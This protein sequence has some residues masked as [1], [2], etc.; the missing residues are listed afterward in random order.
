[1]SG[2][3]QKIEKLLQA[4]FEHGFC[5]LA[6]L[7]KPETIKDLPK[8]ARKIAADME[9]KKKIVIVGDYDVDGV[10]S[11]ALL[12]DFFDTAGYGV[13]VVIPNRFVDGYGLSPTLIER[14]EADLIITVDNG[15]SAVEAADLCAQKGIDL[16]IT[17]HHTPPETLPRAYA[18]V[19]PKQDDCTFAHSEICGAQVAWYLIAQLK[20][21]SGVAYDLKEAMGIVSLAVIADVMPLKHINRAFVKAGLQLLSR[22]TKPFAQAL[23]TYMDTSSFS[24]EDIG[25]FI[26]PRI[27]SAGRMDDAVYAYE[28]LTSSD[29]GSAMEKLQQ[30]NSMNALRKETQ[31]MILAQAKNQADADANVLVVA[32]EFHEGVVG[33]V[34]GHL[35]G[36]FQK[37]AIVLSKKE[38]IY[39]GSGRSWGDID[40]FSIISD[41][42]HLLEGFG[43]H[44]AA[45]G[46]SI[47]QEYLQSFTEAMAAYKYPQ[48]KESNPVLATLAFE[49]IDFDLIRLL[50]KYEP[51]GEANPKPLFYSSGVIV[52]GIRIV[53]ETKTHR[54]LYLRQGVYSFKAIEFHFKS[55]LKINDEIAVRYAVE[56]NSY[57]NQTSIQLQIVKIEL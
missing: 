26:A 12:K 48:G 51:Y 34:A 54:I 21:E 43:G 14:I 10:V 33:I 18:I 46:L 56:E 49:D 37:P 50:Q 24:S 16:I 4:R 40:L 19:N 2:I 3:K 25:F 45:A 5:K 22:S 15:I 23:K 42:S 8:A 55:A 38:N 47:R 44:R 53:G 57:Q 52:D 28:F 35:S 20:K 13:E 32:G 6:D 39:K 41:H 7:P 17:D 29:S 27:N 30:L 9:K 11:S 1:M 31:E 36:H